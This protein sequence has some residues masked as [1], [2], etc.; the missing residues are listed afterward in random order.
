MIFCLGALQV[1]KSK[2]LLSPAVVVGL[3]IS[4]FSSV[5]FSSINLMFFWCMYI[6]YY[7]MSDR[8]I[9][10]HECPSSLCSLIYLI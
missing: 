10:Y 8:L 3:T 7:Y 1:T 4:H 2:M 5:S 9:I 6:C